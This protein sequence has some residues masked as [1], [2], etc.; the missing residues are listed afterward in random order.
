[1]ESLINA[2]LRLPDTENY[3]WVATHELGHNLGYT[4]ISNLTSMHQIDGVQTGISPLSKLISVALFEAN[5]YTINI[6]NYYMID[7]FSGV[8][9]Y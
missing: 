7:Y 1:M 4:H 5:D 9:E 8:Y 2:Y 3:I 6:D